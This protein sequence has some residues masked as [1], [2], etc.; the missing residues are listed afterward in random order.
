MVLA[1]SGAWSGERG[2]LPAEARPPVR[3]VKGEILTLRGPRPPPCARMVA[4]E[5][6]YVVPRARRAPR[7]RRHGR[8]AGVRHARS[9]RAACYELLRE[10]YRAL[11]E[12]AELE[13]VETIAG[14]RPGTPD[15]APLI[16]AG[17]STG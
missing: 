13:L 7:R 9:P 17:R 4:T 8:G 15:N 5:R 11:P 1:A 6:V 10:A 3:P 2:W 12:V 16:G 14:L